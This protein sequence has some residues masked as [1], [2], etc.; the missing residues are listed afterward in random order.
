[1]KEKLELDPLSGFDNSNYIHSV[2]YM[3]YHKHVMF[4][5]MYFC[6]FSYVCVLHKVFFFSMYGHLISLFAFQF[7]ISSS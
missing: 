6:L 5:V 7:R 3:F 4:L 2:P 1:M